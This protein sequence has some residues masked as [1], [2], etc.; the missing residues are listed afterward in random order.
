MKNEIMHGPAQ[1][2]TGSGAHAPSAAMRTAKCGAVGL[3]VAFSVALIALLAA[4]GCQRVG[5]TKVDSVAKFQSAAEKQGWESQDGKP[6]NFIAK[7][8]YNL[9]N[10][11]FMSLIEYRDE[12]AARSAQEK[13]SMDASATPGFK[14]TESGS[15]TSFSSLDPSAG[16]GSLEVQFGKYRFESYG[17]RSKI[18]A[19][20]GKLGYL[21]P[22][23]QQTDSIAAFRAAVKESGITTSTD[24]GFSERSAF[25]SG[26]LIAEFKVFYSP[27]DAKADLDTLAKWLESEK[28]EFKVSGEG[29]GRSL[30]FIVDWPD[31]SGKKIKQYAKRVYS[32]QTMIAVSGPV[33]ERSKMDEFMKSLGY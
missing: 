5:A 12:N 25:K 9:E 14:K 31:S 30:W 13:R 15:V 18:D 1:P 33:E 29:A 32:G 23:R 10:N 4:A 27:E 6:A 2:A 17:N 3:W 22:N 24:R 21:D 28:G 20:I 26:N 7:S 11:A 16:M 19:L 8:D